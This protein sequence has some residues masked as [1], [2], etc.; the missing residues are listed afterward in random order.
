MIWEFVALIVDALHA[1]PGRVTVADRYAMKRRVRALKQ[2]TEKKR[3]GVL[4]A[5]GGNDASSK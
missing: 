3:P 1:I 5:G 4:G 2:R